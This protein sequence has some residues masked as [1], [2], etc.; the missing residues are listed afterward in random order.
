MMYRRKRQREKGPLQVKKILFA[1]IFAELQR[2]EES[3]CE[4]IQSPYKIHYTFHVAFQR[5]LKC[6][7]LSVFVRVCACVCVVERVRE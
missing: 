5:S 1:K 3:R 4:G 2:A 6:L 7:Y